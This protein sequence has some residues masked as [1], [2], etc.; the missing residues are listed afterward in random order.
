LKHS[1]R[2]QRQYLRRRIT[3]IGAKSAVTIFFDL[4]VAPKKDRRGRFDCGIKL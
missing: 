3:M 1:V 4:S 2:N